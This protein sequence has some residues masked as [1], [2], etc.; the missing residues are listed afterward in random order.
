M[1]LILKMARKRFGFSL[2]PLRY[3]TTP[4][5]PGDNFIFQDDDNFIFEDDNNF[6]FQ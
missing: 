2:N 4:D 1:L 5:A 3:I 6:T